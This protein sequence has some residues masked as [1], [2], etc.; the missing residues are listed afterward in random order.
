MCNLQ[1]KP[2]KLA[3]RTKVESC[4]HGNN[5]PSH[6]AALMETSSVFKAFKKNLTAGS[7]CKQVN[8]IS[9]LKLCSELDLIPSRMSDQAELL[10]CPRKSFTV[11]HQSTSEFDQQ[12]TADLNEPKLK[13]HLAERQTHS[14]P[15]NP[16]PTS[17]P[18]LDAASLVKSSRVSVQEGTVC[19]TSAFLQLRL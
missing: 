19:I 8:L 10:P 6:P 1:N 7:N 15:L 3:V 2:D 18:S 5:M 13:V 11:G 4:C 16:K 12:R 9:D 17:P 14:T